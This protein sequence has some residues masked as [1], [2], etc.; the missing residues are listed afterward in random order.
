M[1]SKFL[2]N[3]WLYPFSLALAVFA[4]HFP[5]LGN[6]FLYFW[7]DQWVV[8]NR[9]TESGINFN[10]LWAILT[11]FYHGQYA[12]LNESLYLILYT[13]FG[14]NPFWFHLASLLLHSAN[15]LL[16]YFC[17]KLL[18][19]IYRRFVVE[20]KKLTAFFTALI[21][22]LH[23]FNGKR[24]KRGNGGSRGKWGK[25]KAENCG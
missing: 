14:Y 8:M 13:F 25:G 16:V 2:D 19:G 24:G 23:P 15:V 5:I 7:D 21:F 12:P 17:I 20:H 10:N 22:A 6:D 11:E 4:A 3:K 1:K 18:L 9:Y